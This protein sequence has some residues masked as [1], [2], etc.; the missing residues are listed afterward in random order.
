MTSPA[1]GPN[2]AAQTPPTGRREA[3]A[4]LDRRDAQPAWHDAWQRQMEAFQ[5]SAWFPGALPAA[6]AVLP[7]AAPAPWA[8]SAHAPAPTETRV[9]PEAA[10]SRRQDAPN[11]RHTTN[12]ASRSPE[13][14]PRQAGE[15]TVRRTTTLHPQGQQAVEVPDG[16]LLAAALNS[17]PGSRSPM[18][19]DASYPSLSLVRASMRGAEAAELAGG[20]V[21]G[22]AALETAPRA[23]HLPVAT[24]LFG[25]PA[26]GESV[27]AAPVSEPQAMGRSA[28]RMDAVARPAPPASPAPP[29]PPAALQAF[30]LA[31]PGHDLEPP[32]PASR[33][34]AAVATLPIEPS[35]APSA[36]AGS[37]TAAPASAPALSEQPPPLA[38]SAAGLPLQAETS[39]AAGAAPDGASPPRGDGP[40]PELTRALGRALKPSQA[41]R[42]HIVGR[43]SEVQVWV[44]I[45]AGVDLAQLQATVRHV[46]R[47][48]GLQLESLVCNGR[49]LF[50]ARSPGS[51]RQD[52][53]SQE[54]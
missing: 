27:H 28:P 52:E 6:P 39:Q 31:A 37:V 45:D 9:L 41:P 42:L 50:N 33:S 2:G 47:Q 54:N 20:G 48:Q 49:P 26:H 38:T 44:G 12:P 15:R 3:P 29:A 25:T 51:A 14:F 30:G 17:A 13:V 21:D 36:A 43:G 53:P 34:T 8:A 11:T 35:I 22:V 18:L 4:G 19:A 40:V 7:A 5:A 1:I 46:L 16:R 23:A 10:T 24:A 32:G